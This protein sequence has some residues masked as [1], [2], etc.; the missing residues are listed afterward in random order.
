MEYQGNTKRV[1]RRFRSRNIGIF[2]LVFFFIGTFILGYVFFLQKED[3]ES[4]PR[5]E[6]VS[7]EKKDT[8]FLSEV[9]VIPK[10]DTYLYD[11]KMLQLANTPVLKIATTSSTTI[12]LTDIK[13]K[14]WPVKTVYPNYGALLPFNRIVAYYGN[15]YSPRMGILGE[16]TPDVLIAKLS[17]DVKVWKDADPTTPVIPAIHYIAAVAQ[18]DSG[19]DGKYLYRMPKTQVEKALTLAKQANAIVFLDLQIGKS[20]VLDEVIAIKEYLMFPEVHVA[21]DPEFSMKN[22]KKPGTVIGTID[23]TDINDAI[24]ILSKV[25]REN[26]LP[27]K[28]LVIHRFTKDSL[29]NYQNIKIVPEVQ[30]VIDMDG[31]GPPETK[32]ITYQNII[33]PE[34]VQFTGF[35][36]FYKNDLLKPSTRLIT[37]EEILKLEPQPSYI[38]YQ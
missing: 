14:L 2:F 25:V 22:D 29:T 27:P 1:T 36:I 8:V 37:P 10:L 11:K 23:A 16:Y 32:I 31:W 6:Y 24:E 12:L 33:Y 38:Q 4:I 18:V 9:V 7:I 5:L 34:P 35:K 30:V 26:N 3:M 20:T 21:L 13:Q 15:F 28:I 17:A 19:I